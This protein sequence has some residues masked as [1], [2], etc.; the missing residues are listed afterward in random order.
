MQSGAAQRQDS[1]GYSTGLGRLPD[2]A[3]EVLVLVRVKLCG[4]R[5]FAGSSGWQNDGRGLPG[6]PLRRADVGAAVGAGC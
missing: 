3:A 2:V 5:A 1:R 4:F 6:A